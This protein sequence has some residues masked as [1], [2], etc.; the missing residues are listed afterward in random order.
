MKSIGRLIL[1]LLA[2]FAS[3]LLVI[4]AI[5]LSILE[6]KIQLPLQ[7]PTAALLADQPVRIEN[8]PPKPGTP[9]PA[10]ATS[11]PACV[12]PE[13]WEAYT[14]VPGDTLE[15]LAEQWS[16]TVDELY[17]KNCLFSSSLAAGYTLY[18]PPLPAPSI[19]PTQPMQPSP[20]EPVDEPAAATATRILCGP[21][22]GWITYVVQ[23][24]DTLF[25]IAFNYRVTV[26]QLKLA[27]CLAGDTIRTGQRLFVPN[28]PTRVP[29]ATQTPTD[30][31]PPQP[32]ATTAV[33]PT[34]I[35][36]DIPTELPTDL[37][38]ELPTD[39]PT[40]EPTD[41]QPTQTFMN[42]LLPLK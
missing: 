31:P 34:D 10:P 11:T 9:M 39:L 6:G 29:T 4:S 38:T 20:E 13:D 28:V 36:T 19:T 33:P 42:P 8:L 18:H 37:P 26:E 35:P 32:T 24:G 23:S 41:E 12:V 30:E 17:E 7:T 22:P 14:I 25:R 16:T 3:S 27:N 1:G 2:A 40:A 21:P 15:T 5:S